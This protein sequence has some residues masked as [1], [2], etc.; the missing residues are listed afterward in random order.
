[1]VVSLA[2]VNGSHYWPVIKRFP[3]CSTSTPLFTW[4]GFVPLD[5]WIEY[6]GPTIASSSFSISLVEQ[7][8]VTLYM[9]FCWDIDSP[10][11]FV[12]MINYR[13]WIHL[14]HLWPWILFAYWATMIVSLVIHVLD[15][16]ISLWQWFVY[17]LVC[18]RDNFCLTFISLSGT[19]VWAFWS[20][21]MWPG[22]V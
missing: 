3:P 9:T 10:C 19:F 20:W 12:A 2:F 18:H 6:L 16:P 5:S 13:A 1:M 22:W 8:L 4:L 15:L 11:I 17:G 21:I 14:V 7:D